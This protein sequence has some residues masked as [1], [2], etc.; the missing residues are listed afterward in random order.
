VKRLIAAVLLLAAVCVPVL[1]YG[2]SGSGTESYEPTRIM[3]YRAT[4]D[5][6]ADGTLRAHETIP[7]DIPEYE[8]R[9]GIFRFWD[10]HDPS[11]PGARRIPEN[12]EVTRDGSPE[13]FEMLTE[14]KGRYRVAKIGN[15]YY[16][17][18]S[19]VSTYDIR[20]RI[21]G[22]IEKGTD[23]TRS[24]F[25]WNLIPGGWAQGIEK[26]VLTVNLPAPPE[27]VR[28]AVGQGETS[29]CTAKANGN[30]ITVQTGQL[31]PRTPVTLKVG[32]DVPTPESGHSLWWSGRWDPVLGTSKIGLG[33]VLLLGL[34][35]GGIGMLLARASRED[36]PPFPLM[37]APPEGVGPAQAA[38]VLNERSDRSAF[39]ASLMYA[40]EKGAVEVQRDAK[41]WTITDVGGADRW[42]GLDP[43]T[44]RVAR[45]LPGQ[46]GS[47]VAEPSDITAGQQLRSEM[48]GFTGAVQ[49]WGARNKIL[50]M[51]GAGAAGG[52]LVIGGLLLAGALIVW[53]PVAM[54]LAAVIPGWFA[55]AALPTLRPGSST[56][57]T[58]S[59]RDL[60]SKV[61]GFYRVLST[62]SSID[63][64]EFSGREELYTAYLPWAV[65]F[66]CADVWADKFRTE[67]GVEPPAPAHFAHGY[68]TS[69]GYSDPTSSIDSL[70]R[71]FERT[72]DSSISAYEASIA[73]KSSGGGGGG[74]SGGGGG[75]F[76][77]GGGG[78]GGG[79]GSW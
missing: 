14:G 22:V 40:A 78:G 77:G 48:R 13:N 63:R 34:L 24:Q 28:C 20:Y 12:I 41:T 71:S 6:D 45:L 18:P 69:Q 57:R 27:D 62:P 46:G 26:S 4:F 39:V 3:T 11:A 76:S 52:L 7:V 15:A 33:V 9:R 56:R 16:T 51:A 67:M 30:T 54:S 31:E 5:L 25:Y 36:D 50:E 32:L 60:W 35:A 70:T 66:G 55:I 23:G 65:A 72:V 10:T 44:A 37:Y 64:F 29:G 68:V 19:G 49:S 61:G 73:P 17:L 74:F 2:S 53:N 47:F 59:G 38:Y 8:S 79:G 58:P 43:I 21:D 75:G 42:N 1:A